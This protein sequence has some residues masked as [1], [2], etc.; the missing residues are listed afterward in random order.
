MATNIAAIGTNISPVTDDAEI[1]FA[2]I[3]G[4][5]TVGWLEIIRTAYESII[6]NRVRSILTML[7][8]VIGVASVVTLM[9][10]GAGTTTN[11]TSRIQSIGTNLLTIQNGQPG[12]GPGGPGEGISAE[13]LSNNDAEAILALATAA[14]WTH[15]AVQQQ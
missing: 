13:N 2:P 9:A 1:V 10:I 5:G 8:V 12:K 4:H 11:I 3:D 6:A 14:Q 15:V 7:G